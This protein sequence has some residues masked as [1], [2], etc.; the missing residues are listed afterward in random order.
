MRSRHRARVVVA[1]LGVVALGLVASHFHRRVEGGVLDHRIVDY[2]KSRIV[3]ERPVKSR[4]TRSAFMRPYSEELLLGLAGSHFFDHYRGTDLNAD[5]PLTRFEVAYLLGRFMRLVN[6]RDGEVFPLDRSLDHQE[7]W[8]PQKGWGLFEVEAALAERLF[9]PVW[10]RGWWERQVPRYT[11][12]AILRKV[13]ERLEAHYTLIRFFPVYPP[14][15]YTDFAMYGHPTWFLVRPAIV[16]GLMQDE[17]GAFRGHEPIRGRDAA[18]VLDRLVTI[19][20]GY[21]REP[22]VAM[23]ETHPEGSGMSLGRPDPFPE[24]L[25]TGRHEIL[26]MEARRDDLVQRRVLGPEVREPNAN[27]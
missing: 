8:V 12:A 24:A 10:E 2:Y 6:S 15:H 17:R 19:T 9:A 16:H 20:N 18:L 4:P 23:P 5:Q 14:G 26:E 13:L 21:S 11:L 7:R 25:R 27:P 3:Q 1:A 22:V